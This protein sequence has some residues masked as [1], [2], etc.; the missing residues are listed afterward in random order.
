[1]LKQV[2]GSE[3]DVARKTAA[4]TKLNDGDKVLVV[5]MYEPEMTVVM[6]SAGNVFLRIDAATIP[7]KKRELQEFAV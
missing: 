4:A 1:M 7:E 5:A 6:Q 2:D 3:F